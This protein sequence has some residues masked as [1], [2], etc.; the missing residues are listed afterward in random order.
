MDEKSVICKKKLMEFLKKVKDDKIC[1]EALGMMQKFGE[2][3]VTDVVIRASM[4]AKHRES[5]YISLEDIHFVGEHE[6][7]C[8]FGFLNKKEKELPTEAHNDKI[9]Q[10]RNKKPL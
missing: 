10:I 4:M 2:K 9:A 8:D 3:I 1:P 5:A 7:N 6:F